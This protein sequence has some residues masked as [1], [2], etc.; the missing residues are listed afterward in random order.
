MIFLFFFFELSYMGTMSGTV[1]DNMEEQKIQEFNA[2]FLGFADRGD[3]GYAGKKDA[4]SVQEFVKLY[5]LIKNWNEKNPSDM[6]KIKFATN[7]EAI[8][9]AEKPVDIRSYLKEFKPTSEEILSYY[10][11][12]ERES[13]PNLRNKSEQY[14]FEFKSIEAKRENSRG[15]ISEITLRM[16]KI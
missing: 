7:N 6:I 5:N 4:I 12:D 10:F 2:Q 16:K 13:N 15:R 3:F 14:Y 1:T 11:K 9:I 8:T